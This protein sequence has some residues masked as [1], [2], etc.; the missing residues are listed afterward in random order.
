VESFDGCTVLVLEIETS[1]ASMP[2]EED[3]S[4]LDVSLKKTGADG[5]RKWLAKLVPVPN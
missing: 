2:K 3:E 4:L 1:M 5:E